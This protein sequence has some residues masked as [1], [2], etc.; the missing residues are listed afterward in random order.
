MEC[1]FRCLTPG[2]LVWIVVESESNNVYAVHPKL[3]KMAGAFILLTE[4]GCFC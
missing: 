1:Q 2:L 4:Y 3:E